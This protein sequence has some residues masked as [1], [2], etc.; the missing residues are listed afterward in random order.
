MTA[1]IIV[2]AVVALAAVG[3]LAYFY[4]LAVLT[5][6]RTRAEIA[7]AKKAGKSVLYFNASVLTLNGR[8]VSEFQLVKANKERGV[9]VGPGKYDSVGTFTIHDNDGK[10]IATFTDAE[11]SFTLQS[12]NEYELGVFM[13]DPEIMHSAVSHRQLGPSGSGQG[14]LALACVLC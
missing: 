8:D 12:G 3:T 9:L 10:R 2:L 13:F 11:L 5:A 4:R 7:E 1:G 6:R 14:I